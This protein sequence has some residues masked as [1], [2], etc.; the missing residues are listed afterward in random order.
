MQ[1]THLELIN[2]KHVGRQIFTRLLC[3]GNNG[4]EPNSKSNTYCLG[5]AWPFEMIMVQSKNM[6]D[7]DGIWNRLV[8]VFASIFLTTS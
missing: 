4:G 3:I 8:L 2:L 6:F 7:V 1:G 5:W